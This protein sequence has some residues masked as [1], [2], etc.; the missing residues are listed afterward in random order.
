MD[1]GQAKQV[2]CWRMKSVAR[3]APKTART[4]KTVD[5]TFYLSRPRRG[6]IL[7]E[8]AWQEEDGTVARLRGGQRP[9]DLNR[10]FLNEV[11]E[12]WSREDAS[13]Q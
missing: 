13:S 7:T 5:E 12:L 1:R 4:R 11:K 6:A 8:E 3:P 10:R 2:G 9:R